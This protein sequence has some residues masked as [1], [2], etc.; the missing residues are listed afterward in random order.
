MAST[1][2]SSDEP[3]QT[4]SYQVT[5][6]LLFGVMLTIVGLLG[7]VLGGANGD[8]LVFGRNY[9]HDLVHLGSGLAGLVAGAV[10]GGKNA[11]IYDQTLGIVYLLLS[12][13]G[14]LAVG[15]LVGLLNL[16][17]ADNLLHLVLAVALLGVGFALAE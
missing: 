14:F 6:A 16:D 8:L 12:L 4:G 5:V 11:A 7:P 13:F 17:L 3:T 2:G 9:L 10:A 15:V 1:T